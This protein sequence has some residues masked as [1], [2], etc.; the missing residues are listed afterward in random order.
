M[1]TYLFMLLAI[2][3]LSTGCAKQQF[4]KVEKANAISDPVFGE[5]DSNGANYGTG[6]N[7]G[8]NGNIGSS[9]SNGDE[10]I[11]EADGSNGGNGSNANH[12]VGEG[13]SS[14]IN[15]S[16]IWN[17]QEPDFQHYN[18]KYDHTTSLICSDS[19]TTTVGYNLTS[20]S[21]LELRL[22]DQAGKIIC[23]NSDTT[24]IRNEIINNR[25]LPIP[26]CVGATANKYALKLVDPSKPKKLYDLLN[27]HT[28]NAFIV[29]KDSSSPWAL[30]DRSYQD[31]PVNDIDVLYNNNKNVKDSNCDQRASPLIVKTVKEDHAGIQLTSQRDG[32]WFDILGENSDPAAHVKKRISWI[33]KDSYMFLVKPN[34]SGKVRGIDEMFGDNTKGP[35]GNFADDGYMALAKYDLNKDGVIDSKDPVYKDLK[36]W[37]DKNRDGRSQKDE[38]ISLSDA[39]LLAIDLAYDD[40]FAEKDQYGN[41]TRMKSVVKY[42]DGS[43]RLIFDVWFNY[44]GKRQRH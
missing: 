1:K 2:F 29:R 10:H 42:S 13:D 31:D 35:D 33:T 14:D 5:T 32:I 3:L 41:E 9:G 43:Y 28:Q 26:D 23:K 38:L 7:D 17:P 37:S 24:Q 40:S 11:G 20:A 25:T 44:E 21:A 30:V 22:V 4:D 8:S 12:N 15:N 16:N 6:E 18:G 39:G 36:L 27:F 34:A 19:R